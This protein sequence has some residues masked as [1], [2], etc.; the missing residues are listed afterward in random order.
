MKSIHL[1]LALFSLAAACTQAAPDYPHQPAPLTQVSILDGFWLPRFETNRT[2]TVWTD[3]KRSEETGRVSNFAR[4]GKLEQGPFVGIYFND[5]D[6]YKIIEGAAYTLATKP[7]PKLDAY[8]DALIVKI[9]AAQEPDGYL[10]TARTLGAKQ[11]N[12]G[13]TRW[14]YIRHSHELYNVGH[15]YE[16]A[17][18]HFAITGKRTLLDVAI[19]NADLIDKTFGPREG[20]LKD[21][22]GHEEIE[23][24]LCSLFRV[25]GERRYLDLAKFFTDLRGRKDL[26][27]SIYGPYHQDHLPVVEQTEAVGHAV[28]AGYLYAGMA[29]IAALTGDAKYIAAIDKLWENVVSKKLHLN[30]GIGARHSGEAFG[31]NYEL[32]NESAYLETC[33]AIANGLWNQRM[34]LLHGDAKYIDV[35]ERGLYNGV[36][37]GISFSG[38]EFFYPNPL[39]SR[40]GYKRSKWFDCSCCPGNIVRFIPQFGQFAYARRDAAIYVNLFI[41]SSAALDTPSGKVTLT[42]QT[43]YPW[44][45]KIRI[46]VTPEKAGAAFPLKVRIPGWALGR[47]VPSDLYTQVVPASADTVAIGVNGQSVPLTLDKGYVTI[48]RAWQAGDVVTLSLAMPVRR[49]QSHPAVKDNVGRLAVERGPVVYCAEGVDNDGHVLNLALPADAT[50][51]EDRLN[52]QGHE[53]V[54]LKA[55]AQAISASFDGIK[56]VAPVTATLIPYFA[57]CHRGA[58]EMQVWFPAD[59]ANAESALSG[60]KITTS[61]ALPSPHENLSAVADRILPRNSGDH[62]VQRMTWW[63]HKGSAEWVQYDLPRTA[64]FRGTKVYWFDDTGRGECRIPASWKIQAQGADGTWTDVPASYPVKK[65]AFGEVRFAAP[66]TAKAFRLSVQLQPKFSA[67]VLEWSL[68]PK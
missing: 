33:A 40:G 16:A 44:S 66:V 42:Q 41:A 48:D 17:A 51:T 68:L 8:L 28:R 58:G 57:W 32:P 23:I 9:A 52:I 62:N 4:A 27:G 3:F 11:K 45:G 50:F 31:N 61:Y 21:V 63:D 26:R 43:D 56:E 13:K 29:D 5:S 55:P 14:S 35:L 22:P 47:P 25:T 67:G 54:A 53:L 59:S 39:A 10:Y 34:F 30:G 36:L 7:D 6:V 12:M 60:V 65:N 64:T 1:A 46:A 15:L 24:G 38:D 37:S 49:I 19:K 2:V 20:Q 18:A